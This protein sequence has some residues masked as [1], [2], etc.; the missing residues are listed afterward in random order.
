MSEKYPWENPIDE[1]KL[2]NVK[3]YKDKYPVSLGHLLYVPD[4]NTLNNIQYAFRCAYDHGKMMVDTKQWAG[5][6]IGMNYGA[7]AGQTIFHPH[8]HLIPRY[9]GDV[10][11][12]VGGIRNVIPG[13]GNYKK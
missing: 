12:P 2:P 4:Y 13:K 1:Q 8:I 3:V 6:N 9:T 11:D 7:A 5:F 10:S